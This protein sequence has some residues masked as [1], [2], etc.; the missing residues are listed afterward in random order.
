MKRTPGVHLLAHERDAFFFVG[1][2]AQTIAQ[3]RAEVQ[4]RLPGADDRNADKI[5]RQL[6]AGIQCAERDNGIITI[7]LSSLRHFGDERSGREGID[8][9]IGAPEKSRLDHSK[10]NLGARRR[11]F[12]DSLS[13]ALCLFCGIFTHDHHD[14]HE[15]TLDSRSCIIKNPSLSP[16]RVKTPPLR[17]AYPSIPTSR[18]SGSRSVRLSLV[19]ATSTA[20]SKVRRRVFTGSPA[21]NDNRA[22]VGHLKSFKSA[23]GH[24]L[25][26][27]FSQ[28]S[29]IQFALTPSQYRYLL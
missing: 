14:F 17:V 23:L 21:W 1:N 9:R 10:A 4:N 20:V 27:R 18:D 24:G 11:A 29:R 3:L 7:R 22:S 28:A 26:D 5:S 8:L 2:Y 12:Q 16:D 15:F 19:P 25:C 13:T 6:Y